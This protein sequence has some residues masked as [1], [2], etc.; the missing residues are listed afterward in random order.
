MLCFH[1]E[2]K[3]LNHYE[4]FRKYRCKSCNQVLMCDCEQ[5]LALTFLGHQVDFAHEYGTRERIPVDGFAPLICA[6]CR[7]EREEP[8]PKAEIW[9]LKGKVERYYWRE[10]FKTYYKLLFEHYGWDRPYRDIIKH[11]ARFP[12]VAKRL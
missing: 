4:V 9:G 2:V 1:P 7:G 6:E 11:D 3:C 8:H 12:E 5:K 10:I